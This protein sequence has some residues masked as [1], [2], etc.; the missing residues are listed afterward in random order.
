MQL[1]RYDLRTFYTSIVC[2]YNDGWRYPD[3]QL[4]T[5]TARYPTWLIRF[6]SVMTC[7]AYN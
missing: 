4:H 5:F 2:T 3:A 1:E 7:I 6:G